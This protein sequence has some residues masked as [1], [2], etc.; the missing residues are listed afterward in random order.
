MD[1]RGMTL[2]EVLIALLILGLI[3]QI[4]FSL[5]FHVNRVTL[6]TTEVYNISRM[7]QSILEELKTLNNRT[8]GDIFHEFLDKDTI[9]YVD[10]YQVQLR[11]HFLDKEVP[12]Y[13]IDLHVRDEIHHLSYSLCSY[14]NAKGDI[15]LYLNG[16][17]ELSIELKE[18]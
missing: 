5:M 10:N 17:K 13:Q 3:A 15:N 4:T 2:V 11:I 6:M 12:L 16:Y 18:D 8:E 7:A 1:R 14:I 9:F